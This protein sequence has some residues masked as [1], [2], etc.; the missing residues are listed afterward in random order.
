MLSWDRYTFHKKRT[1]RC[2]TEHVF[3]HSLGSVG[4]VVQSGASWAQNVDA[5]FFMLRWDRYTFHKKR[6]GRCYTEHVFSHSL[7]S[8][9]HV[10]QSGASWAQNVDSLFFML[11][12]DRYRCYAEL[13]FLH[14]V[15]PGCEMS[16]QYFHARVDPG[17]F[18]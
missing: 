4:H 13:V 9:G 3:S 1:G 12:W 14:T 15:R 17:W 8:V 5:L 16:V 10:V 6:T 2:Y 7:G 11:R 18:S